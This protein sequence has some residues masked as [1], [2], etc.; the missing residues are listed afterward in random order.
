MRA[1]LFALP[2]FLS[3]GLASAQ[4][5]V[6]DTI[7]GGNTQDGGP[8][9]GAILNQ[10]FSVAVSIDGTVYIA[11][12]ANDRIRRVTPSG[13]ISTVA[14]NG[15][16]GFS[17]D[18]GPAT[19]AQLNN[20]KSVAIAPDGT[21]YIADA[22]N[23]RIR[24]VGPAGT[25]S[26]LAG[27]GSNGFS[28]DG[29]P[30][31]NAR[32]N[33]PNG[34]TVSADGTVF[35]ADL[36]NNRIR[37]V[38]TDGTISTVGS[39]F[40]P[41]CVAAGVD[42]SVYVCTR[43]PSQI[44]LIAADG[45]VSTVAGNGS[46]GYSGDGG[47]A[48][49]AQ[50]NQPLG[51]AVGE[52][53]TL[54]IADTI[55]NRIRLVRADGTISSIAG[56]GSSG[57]SGDDGPAVS[58]QLSSPVGVALAVDGSVYV[59]DLGNHR[60]RLV[61]T[62]GGISTVA[63]GASPTE[64]TGDGGPALGAQLNTPSSIAVAGDGTLYVAD[65]DKSRIR[66]IDPNGMITTVAGTGSN[67]F[68]GDGGPATSAQLYY[69]RGVAL[70]PDGSLLIADTNNSRIRRLD[71]DGTISTVVGTGG[72]GAGGEGDGGPATDAILGRP[73][74]IAVA[75]DGTIYIADAYSYKVRR[76]APDG[77]ISTVAGDPG[78]WLNI[79][80]AVAV[81]ID[82][83]VFI[84]DLDRI[85]RINGDGSISVVAGDQAGF[86]GDGGPAVSARLS[87]PY[88]L[89]VGMDGTLYIADT[90]N[91]RIRRIDSDGNIWTVAGD[92]AMGFSGDGGP[93]ASA[94]F[95]TPSGVAVSADG[96]LYIADTNNN[97]IRRVTSPAI[98]T[99][100]LTKTHR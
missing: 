3:S 93:A 35:V 11:D 36:G 24:R 39:F 46:S 44:S 42:G 4:S 10:P 18:A 62:S 73:Y 28:G 76:V 20:P 43:F 34:V 72:L 86:G 38:G 74:G 59:A 98:P 89:A 49:S 77:T 14:G 27:N 1:T 81:G 56:A 47:L 50:L 6:I 90:L 57:F 82:G 16:S 31:A 13:M 71:P 78:R 37:R 19:Q 17:G 84:A 96:T 55:N 33:Q 48:A 7:A 53:G 97:R 29:G 75:A 61:G 68:S 8:A 30:A 66:R 79:P 92:G 23:N 91:Q 41:N 9:T 21:L 5:G 99:A 22:G 85:R 12:A 63:G 83:T 15:S 65:T 58:A 40:N 52:N 100:Q 45:T 2:C 70:A 88:G 87:S 95:R 69:P 94:E 32:L 60:I 64:F 67:G 25:I 54:Y 80:H 26:T 51:V